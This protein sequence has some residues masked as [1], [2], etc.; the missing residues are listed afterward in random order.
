MTVPVPAASDAW[1]DPDAVPAAAGLPVVTLEVVRDFRLSASVDAQAP[2][3]ALLGQWKPRPRAARQK[4]AYPCRAQVAKPE[5]RPQ[6]VVSAL[7]Q[8]DAPQVLRDESE[9]ARARTCSAQQAQ[10]LRQ[11]LEPVLRWPEQAEPPQAQVQP[12]Q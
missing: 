6:A 3:L 12:G 5:F 11:A 2:P 7:E 4:A 8:P 10:A 1:A 9:Q